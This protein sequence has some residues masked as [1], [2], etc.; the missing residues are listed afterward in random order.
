MEREEQEDVVDLGD[1]ST[2]TKGELPVG[3][4]DTFNQLR[5]MPAAAE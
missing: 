3:F 2:E 5:W 1:V 4:M